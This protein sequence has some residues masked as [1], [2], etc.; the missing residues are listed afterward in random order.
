MNSR[1]KQYPLYASIIIVGGG[2]LF[3]LIETVRAKNTGFETKTLWDWM[4]LLIIPFVLGI[5]AYYLNRSERKTEREIALDRQQEVALQAYLD[6]MSELLLKENLLTTEDEIVRLVA[7]TRTLTVLRVLDGLR[8]RNVLLFLRDA[9]LIGAMVKAPVF[10]LKSA[11]LSYADL[12]GFNLESVNLEEVNLQHADFRGAKMFETNFKK[13][14]L[15]YANLQADLS[16][17]FFVEADLSN[18]N[19]RNATMHDS[20]LTGAILQYAD[21]K[22]AEILPPQ[23]LEIVQTLKG[24]IMPDGTKHE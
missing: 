2:L 11:D 9:K 24:A 17:S 13:A 1:W 4:E 14:D 5:G 7:Q 19:M 3:I 20:N 12:R 10:T 18:T 15:R 21:L 23:A 6:R 8:K 22:G 16:K